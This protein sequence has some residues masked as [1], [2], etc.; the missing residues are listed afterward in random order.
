[1]NTD[2]FMTPAR[3]AAINGLAIVGFVALVVA[4]I[5][6]AVYS[7]R[8]VPAV[9][10]RIGGAAVYLGSV[11]TPA[12]EPILSV[13]PTPTASTTISFG[14]SSSTTSTPTT[15]VSTNPIKTTAGEETNSTYQIDGTGS[16]PVLRGLP[17]LV[18]NVVNIGYLTTTSSDSFVASSTVPSG[19]RPAIK[20]TIKNI[21][22]NVTGQWR[23]NASIPT[24]SSYLYYSPF[25][26]SLNPGDS[27][28][29]TLG[30]DQAIAG[31]DKMIS[32]SANFDH[33]VTESNFNNN[34]ASAQLT[35]LGS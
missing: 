12:D 24:Q 35:I 13:V 6:L 26:Q 7:T 20:F 5:W 4:G 34:S 2:Q 18:I 11:F 29:Y 28:D 17:D 10:N 8:F 30:F 1:M 21:G 15:P 27:I 25:Q 16:V 19:A 33:V 3:Q 32:I 23:F 14:T 22:T 31:S 9:V